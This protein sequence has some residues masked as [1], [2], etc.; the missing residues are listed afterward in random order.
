MLLYT[1]LRRMK[2][3][4]DE[5]ISSIKEK[6]QSF[7]DPEERYEFL[8]ELGRKA[9]PFPPT[10]KI[11]VNIVPGCQSTLYLHTHFHDDKLFFQ[12][13]SEALISAG[14]AALLIEVY[15]DTP[16]QTILC[17]PPNFL[18]EIGLLA[19]LSPSRSNGL[20]SIYLRM[21]QEA[22]KYIVCCKI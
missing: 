16:P 19:S 20:A 12:A 8:I 3:I 2:T 9:S 21:K 17:N 10:L 6:F 22:L 18:Q 4:F 15:S 5:R 1:L 14:L 13:H 7:T 11:P